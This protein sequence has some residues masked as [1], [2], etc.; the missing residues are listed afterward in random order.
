MTVTAVDQFG[1]TVK[2]YAGTAFTL[3]G[4]ATLPTPYQFKAVDLGRHVFK[5][6]FR[7]A[8]PSHRRR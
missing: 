1:N 8:G 4:T 3:V 2:G 5:V 6:T 7:T